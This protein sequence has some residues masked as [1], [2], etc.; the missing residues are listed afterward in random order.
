M[1]IAG[2]GRAT[3]RCDPSGLFH[4]SSPLGQ[5]ALG[6]PGPQLLP[7]CTQMRLLPYLSHPVVRPFRR[8]PKACQGRSFFLGGG[9]VGQKYGEE[10]PWVL[11]S[12]V[13]NAVGPPASSHCLGG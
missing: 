10:R 8:C 12:A 13:G 2:Q 9:A 6:T 1:Q 4:Q 11:S 7:Y 5:T 3:T